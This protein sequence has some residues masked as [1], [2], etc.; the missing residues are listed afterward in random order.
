IVNLAGAS[1]DSRW[2]DMHRK[3]ILNSRVN[4]GT[5][6]TEAIKAADRKP[7]VLIQSSAVGYYGPC[8]DEIIT[9][10]SSA[11]RDFLAGVCKEWEASTQ[12][13]EEMGVRRCVIRSGIILSRRGGVMKRLLPI[14]KLGGGGTVGSGKQYYPWIHIGD[15]VDAIRFLIDSKKASGVFNLSA[16][17]PVRNKEFTKA[18]GKA[19]SRPTLFPAPAIPM[20]I[21]FG[22]MA[23]II[24]D[25]QRAIPQHLQEAGYQFR[26]TE[27]ESAFRHLL[28]SGVEK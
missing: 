12:A 13:V 25:G 27:L 21:V 22:E 4:A 18:L 19:L 15:E 16:P 14:F 10:D 24:L 28:Y 17:E 5:A 3:R 26:F 1:I 9:E 8:R 2:T 20:R 11:G 7:G 6:V 23:T